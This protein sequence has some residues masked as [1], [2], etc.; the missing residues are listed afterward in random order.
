VPS[1]TSI[2][3]WGVDM[4]VDFMLPGGKLYVP[5]AEKLIPNI[6]R[7]VD[8]ARSGN[9]LMVASACQHSKNDPEFNVFPPH[10]VRG[11]KGAELIPEA[12]MDGVLRVP[13][14][15]N[16]RLSANLLFHP[17]ILIEKQ[18]LDVFESKQT[19]GIVNALPSGAEFFIFGVVTEFCVRCAGKGLLERGRRVVIIQD[20]IETL[21]PAIGKKTVDE[22]A[23]AGAHFI[24]TD[25]AL[26]RLEATRTAD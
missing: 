11:T 12:K 19:A 7:L 15:P 13:N 6:K 5:G 10:C 2:V 26:A 20:A 24:S 8:T 18:T 4:Q 14:D 17:Q 25:E 9:T 1:Q 22:L 23:A 3:L 21:D 16:F